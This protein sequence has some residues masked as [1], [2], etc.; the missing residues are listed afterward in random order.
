MIRKPENPYSYQ[1]I[2]NQRDREKS[3]FL[4]NNMA[5]YLPQFTQRE[6]C[7]LA[8]NVAYYSAKIEGSSYTWDEAQI[9]L[10]NDVTAN[11]GYDDALVLKNIQRTFI[12][13]AD[14]IR[15]EGELPLDS[16]TVFTLNSMLTFMQKYTLSIQ[17]E[18]HASERLGINIGSHSLELV[19]RLETILSQHERYSDPF[20]R[21][22]Y[23]HCNMEHLG[24]FRQGNGLTARMAESISLMNAGILP[25]YSH[26][27]EDITAY[28]SSMDAYCNNLDYEPYKDFLLNQQVKHMITDNPKINTGLLEAYSKISAPAEKGVKSIRRRMGF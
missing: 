3:S 28:K 26:K 7:N 17:P 4:H 6:V 14:R 19:D 13:A 5:R 18:R 1:S 20:E 9:L 21:A 8:V 10:N 12:A 11:R 25:V 24:M 16:N 22:V 27:Q 23:L 15:I 2:F